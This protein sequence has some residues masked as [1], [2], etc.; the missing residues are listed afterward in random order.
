MLPIQG[1]VAH[2][3]IKTEKTQLHMALPGNSSNAIE[4]EANN[5]LTFRFGLSRIYSRT[6]EGNAPRDKYWKDSDSDQSMW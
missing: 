2:A 3:T 4:P 5:T 6:R 1:I